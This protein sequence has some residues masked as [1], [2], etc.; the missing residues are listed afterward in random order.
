VAGRLATLKIRADFLRVAADRHNAVMPGLVL[1][2]TQQP[3][4]LEGGPMLRVGFTAS[5]KVGNAVIRNRAKRRLRAAAAQ[6]LPVQGEPRY[7]LRVDRAGGD[8]RAALWG[9][10]CRSRRSA[11]QG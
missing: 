8:G 11:A 4:D 5:R 1:Q 9:A 2:V 6:I 10:R 7:R 3:P